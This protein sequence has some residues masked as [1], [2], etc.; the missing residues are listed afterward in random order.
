MSTYKKPNSP[1][2]QYDFWRRGRRFLGSTG[3]TTKREADEV[4]R[5]KREQADAEIRASE[6]AQ[7][8]FGGG[9][10]LNLDVA[11]GR[12]WTERGQHRADADDCWQAIVAMNA[13]FGPDRLLSSITDSDVAGWVAKVRGQTVRGVKKLKDGSPAPLLSPARVNRLTVDALR[14]IYGR[15]RKAWKIVFPNEPDWAQH[16]LP[17]P[18]E[19]VRELTATEESALT[20]AGRADYER[21]YRFARLSGLRLTACL[22]RKSAVKW[23]IGRIEIRSKNGKL[24]RVPLSDPIRALLTECWDDHPEAVFTYTAARTRGKEGQP[25]RRIKG[26]R[27]PITRSGLITQWRRDREE[28]IKT[29]PTLAD[30]RFHDHRHTAATRILRASGNLKIAQKLLNHSRITTT[31]KYAHVLDDE[32]LEAMNEVEKRDTKSRTKSRTLKRRAV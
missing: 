19:R 25:D 6:A 28:A 29:V 15:A 30:F 1:Y 32:V 18:D 22:I 17:E 12:W 5:L 23:D 21:V 26:S 16:R 9:A 2:Y 4:E 3:K 11:T 31:A 14:R 24:N 7:A 13:H 27:Y 10:P 20:A 8:Q